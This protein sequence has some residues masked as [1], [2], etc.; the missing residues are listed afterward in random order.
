MI[1]V[2]LCSIACVLLLHPWLAQTPDK[3][4]QSPDQPTQPRLAEVVRIEAQ[5]TKGFLYPYYFYVPP[6]LE[7]AKGKNLKQCILVLPNNTGKID[8]DLAVHD[9]SARRGIE[10]ARRLA[11]NLK[12]AL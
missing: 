10:D 5:P 3:S 4:S 7:T 1:K 8:D 12:V 6:E 2:S 11:A 9:S